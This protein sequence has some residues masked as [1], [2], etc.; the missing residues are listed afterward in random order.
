MPKNVVSD[1]GNTPSQSGRKKKKIRIKY[2][3]RVRI[4]QRP[5]GNKVTRYLAKNKKIV[6][7]YII[8]ISLLSTTL[9]MLGKLAVNRVEI[10]KLEKDLNSYTPK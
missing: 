10:N 5:K 4:T 8:L 7:S 2:R 6:V 9:F 3:E 1:E